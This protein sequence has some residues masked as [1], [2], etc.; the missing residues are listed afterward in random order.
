MA[1][2]T[3]DEAGYPALEPARWAHCVMALAGIALLIGP[4][5]AVLWPR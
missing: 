3:R 2:G 5:L 4:A 1:S